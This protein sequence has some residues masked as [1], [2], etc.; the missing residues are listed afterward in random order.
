VHHVAKG[1]GSGLYRPPA[2]VQGCPSLFFLQCVFEVRYIKACYG[3][4]VDY[5]VFL[6]LGM[7]G[8]TILWGGGVC[9]CVCVC[10]CVC[11]EIIL[12]ID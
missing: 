3:I 5:S 2:P 12:S 8:V 9:L 11:A 4:T 1:G 6:R 10:V 7:F